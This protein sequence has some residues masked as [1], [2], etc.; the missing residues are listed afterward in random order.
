[1]KTFFD[2]AK[3]EFCRFFKL[4]P[5]EINTVEKLAYYGDRYFNY[6]I[7]RTEGLDE[8]APSLEFLFYNL[9]LVFSG[10]AV[11]STRLL[12]VIVNH[13][14]TKALHRTKIDLDFPDFIKSLPENCCH[15]HIFHDCG[16]DYIY[17]INY[18]AKVFSRDDTESIEEGIIAYGFERGRIPDY[19][20]LPV[21]QT[22][23]FFEKNGT[24]SHIRSVRSM[25]F[26]NRE[27]YDREPNCSKYHFEDVIPKIIYYLKKNGNPDLRHYSPP[28]ITTKKEKKAKRQ[29]GDQSEFPAMNVGFGFGKDPLYLK[30]EWSYFR[31]QACGPGFSERKLIFVT[32]H[33]KAGRDNG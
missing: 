30:D 25:I 29:L 18:P 6:L 5:R 11:P 15:S 26:E 14:L 9:K 17:F 32:A 28:A 2:I 21:S 23:Y 24:L 10:L 3:T 22:T 20:F 16:T 13:D 4:N 1:M 7:E 33:R 27:I 12:P 19:S 31:N 8:K